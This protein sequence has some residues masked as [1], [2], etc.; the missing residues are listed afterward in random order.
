MDAIGKLDQKVSNLAVD[1][2]Q[3]RCTLDGVRDLVNLIS[4]GRPNNCDH[5]RHADDN[6]EINAFPS[7][8]NTDAVREEVPRNRVHECKCE[9]PHES[10]SPSI[11]QGRDDNNYR[12]KI[13][14]MI[15]SD[16]TGNYDGSDHMEAQDAQYVDLS[17]PNSRP[18]IRKFS[19]HTKK[20]NEFVQEDIPIETQTAVNDRVAERVIRNPSEQPDDSKKSLP[21][22]Q[23]SLILRL[24]PDSQFLQ[25]V[26]TQESSALDDMARVQGT[27]GTFKSVMKDLPSG[28]QLRLVVD[29]SW[30]Q[31]RHKITPQQ[32]PVESFGTFNSKDHRPFMD[33]E[34][35]PHN[36]QGNVHGQAKP[37]KSVSQPPII[38]PP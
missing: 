31:R 35:S 37:P 22:L 6:E 15:S 23:S 9:A 17:A 19:S 34:S 8:K 11:L 14:E 33:M 10:I 12:P 28:G 24:N 21:N 36:R 4:K 13:V 5:H 1:S 20:A 2:I 16:E 29:A 32:A 25:V 30:A 3:L 26:E 38:E 27:W 7:H 18:P